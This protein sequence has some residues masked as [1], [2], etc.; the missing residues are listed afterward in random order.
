MRQLSFKILPIISPF[1]ILSLLHLGCDKNFNTVID[2]TGDSP[3]I[4]DAILSQYIINTDTINIGPERKPDDFLGIQIS[5]F[6]NVHC[7][8][9]QNQIGSVRFMV[10]DDL[11]SDPLGEGTLQNNGIRP[12]LSATDSIY[13]GYVTFQMKRVFIGK[14]IV[15]F[16]SENQSGY[17]SN[18][19]LVPLQ[20]ARQNRPPL[21]T[22]IYVPSSISASAQTPFLV[23]VKAVDPDGQ[24]DISKVLM[25]NS[26]TKKYFSLNDSGIE[27][28]NVASDSIYSQYFRTDQNQLLGSYPFAFVAI[29]RS[30]DSSNVITRIIT[31][32]D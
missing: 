14:L 29:D 7:S 19:L 12:D 5:A 20:I 1:I 6:T 9:Y 27:G 13:S 24:S 16:W 25:I 17:K 10:Q 8:N 11:S 23:E 4:S 3:I 22:I 28:D 21:I 18:S 26:N 31:V 30:K 2:S 15:T 32:T